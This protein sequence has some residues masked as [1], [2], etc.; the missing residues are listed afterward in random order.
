MRKADHHKFELNDGRTFYAQSCVIGVDEDFIIYEGFDRV[1]N[2]IE[3]SNEDKNEICDFMIKRWKEAK[4]KYGKN[5][6]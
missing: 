5:T 4:R 1:V 2:E 3:L 6:D